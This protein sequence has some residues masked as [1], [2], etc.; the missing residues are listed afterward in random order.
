MMGVA[1]YL[2]RRGLVKIINDK[3]VCTLC[4]RVFRSGDELVRHFERFHEDVLVATL[5]RR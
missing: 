2:V 1:R 3:Y 4:G 5:R